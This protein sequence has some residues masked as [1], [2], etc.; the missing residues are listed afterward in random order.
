MAN[1]Q[2]AQVRTANKHQK[3]CPEYRIDDKVWLF[4]KNI[5]TERLSKKLDHKRIGPYKVIKLVDSL[6][7]LEL[8]TSIQIHNVFYSNLL[9]LAA[10]DSLPGQI[11]DS[12]PP[13]VVNDKEEWEVD[14]IL[15]AKKHGRRVLFR[16]K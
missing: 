8:P 1:S 13:V 6:Y 5:H 16:A 3:P 2:Q 7:R 9:K 11:N 12:P 4:T 10:K 14:D 15:N